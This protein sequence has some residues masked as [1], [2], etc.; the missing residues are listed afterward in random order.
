MTL[1]LMPGGF[2]AL[3]IYP[4]RIDGGMGGVKS[5]RNALVGSTYSVV[6]DGVWY[7]LSS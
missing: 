1:A 7:G 5:R 4:S 2:F 6:W 3:V